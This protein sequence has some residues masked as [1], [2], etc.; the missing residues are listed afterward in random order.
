MILNEKLISDVLL[1]LQIP[2]PNT[3]ISDILSDVVL[4]RFKGSELW[5]RT[6]MLEDI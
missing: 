1:I 6:H 3:P 4:N 2:T 5:R